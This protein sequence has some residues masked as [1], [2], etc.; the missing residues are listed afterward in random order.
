MTE[1]AVQQ[2]DET[3]RIGRSVLFVHQH[4][5][6]ITNNPLI[7]A[8]IEILL[9]TGRAM[10]FA[11]RL[12]GHQEF[13]PLTHELAHQYALYAG[14]GGLELMN[15]VLP[16]LKRADLI[17]YQLSTDGRIVRLDEFVGITASVT[18]QTVRLLNVL[19]P[20]RSDL[21]FLHS[22]EIGALAPLAE[23]QHLQE[24]VKRGFSDAEANEALRLAKAVKINMTVPS[25]ELREAVVFSPYVWG[26][27]QVSLA[28]FL[29]KLPPNERD[30]LLGMSQQVLTTPGLHIGRLAA[31]PAVVQ[32]A[33]S[34]G[35]IQA[36]TVQSAAG[37]SSTYVFSPLLETEDNQCTT[38]EALHLRK[39][40]VAHIL[41]GH[42]GA[43]AGRGRILS[44]T[45]LVNSLVRKG[46]VGPA[47]N[48]GTD[49]HLLE[50]AG[51]VAVTPGP[52]DRAYLKLIKPE[53]AEAGLEWIRRITDTSG[54]ESLRLHQT[55]AKFETP[56]TL[57]G[58]AASDGAA[59]EI[60]VASI[61]ELRKETQRAARRD[62]PWS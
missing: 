34:V 4:E 16:A 18:E 53:I 51:V 7:R 13:A 61:N 24:I 55:P 20:R 23:S 40:F 5:S 10:D 44:P 37:G 19:S 35:L 33:R 22:V 48:I 58:D 54:T 32:S 1:A 47:T 29:A 8:E 38:T 14:I 17:D 52:D 49:Y 56:E 45:V 3:K 46:A 6:R 59:N 26:T 12:K 43:K 2:L 50:A 31:S 57:R 41:F 21:A 30:A 39:L 9:L 25:D 27:K 62:D 28:N 15:T 60:L 42:E 11:A 36:A